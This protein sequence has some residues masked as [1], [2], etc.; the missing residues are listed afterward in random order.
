MNKKRIILSITALCLV[1]LLGIFL[2]TNRR[3]ELNIKQVSWNGEAILYTDN[4]SK[5]MYNIKFRKFTGTDLKEIESKKDSYTLD[6][7]SKVESGKASIKVYNSDKVLYEKAGS[8]KEKIDVE[9][10]ENV[11]VELKCDDA[12]ASLEIKIR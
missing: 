10:S 4:S 9:S 5:N 2:Y 3:N 7:D 6:I 11:K 1:G 8:I 12:K